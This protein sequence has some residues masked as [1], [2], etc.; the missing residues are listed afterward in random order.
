MGDEDLFDLT[1]EMVPAL[2]D[3]VE[4]DG[5]LGEHATPGSLR[6]AP[7]R[8]APPGRRGWANAAR[9]VASSVLEFRQRE[10]CPSC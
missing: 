6:P 1:A 3:T 5:Q 10:V 4:L 2:I 8:S 9:R 7:S